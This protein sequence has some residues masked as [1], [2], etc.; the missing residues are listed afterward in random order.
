MQLSQD[1]IKAH[2]AQLESKLPPGWILRKIIKPD[3]TL[4]DLGNGY[5]GHDTVY[6]EV[7]KDN[8]MYNEP[9]LNA[10]TANKLNL[11]SIYGVSTSGSNLTGQWRYFIEVSLYRRRFSSS[12]K[13]E[14]ARLHEIILTRPADW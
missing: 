9:L 8:W 10:R 5:Y 14:L 3:G 2:H 12:I 13:Q 1:E 7:D 11:A 4:I 6:I